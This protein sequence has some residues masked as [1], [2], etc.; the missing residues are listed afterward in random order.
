MRKEIFDQLEDRVRQEKRTVWSFD[1][2]LQLVKKDPLKVLRNIFQLFHDMVVEYVGEG[3][4]EYP[5]DPESIGFVKYDCSKI[6]IEGT[7]EPFFPDRLF[8]NRFVR[9][10]KS[11]RQGSR[12]N[13][14]YAY[15]GPPGCGKSRFLN[16]LMG[17]FERYVNSEA[18][19]SYELFWEIDESRY[20]KEVSGESKSQPRKLEVPC[21]NHDYPIL[22]IP[23][24]F[25]K[26]FL[27]QLLGDNGED[28][29]EKIFEEKEYQWISK[30]EVCT[31]CNSIF[32]ELFEKCGS[33]NKVLE[34]VKVRPY[35]F[36]RRIGEGIS[37]FN[38]GDRPPE[39]SYFADKQLQTQLDRLFGFNKVQYLFSPL[40]RTNNGIYVL[41]DVKDH[42]KM[43]L[44]ELH[45][46]ISE[47]VHKVGGVI[48]ENINSLFFALMNPEDKAVL[49]EQKGAQSIHG[50]I[51][52]N[53]ITYVLEVQ[54]EMKIYKSVFGEHIALRFLPHVLENFCRIIIAS[55]MN[56]ECPPLK[57]WIKDLTKYKRY[58]DKEGRLLRMEL[59]SGVIPSWLS[60][61]DRK[62]FS[63]SARRKLITEAERE[64]LD[65]ATG[66]RRGFT[67]RDSIQLFAEFFTRYGSRAN[68]INMAN[69][70][71][72]FKHGIGKEQRDKYIPQEF[73]ASLE[74]WYDY[75]VLNEVK[76]A[77]YFYNKNQ[78][79][80]DILH[81][82]WAVNYDLGAKTRCSYT[83]KE[84][85]VTIDF[86]KLIGGYICGRQLSDEEAKTLALNYQK[87]YVQFLSQDPS[88]D[89]TQTEFYQDLLHAYTAN[90]KEKALQP[91]LKNETFREAIKSFGTQE[92][93]PF[94]ERLKEHVRHMIKTLVERFGYTEEGA[95]EVC[96]Y[97]LDKRLTEKF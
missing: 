55:R 84:I 11:L 66:E 19:R 33:L 52:Y 71:E 57:E 56:A 2:Y 38:P 64:G 61:E 21:P 43:R 95:R 12:Q 97:V 23:K 36:N 40:S 83:N 30:N 92:F 60:D 54:T 47:G 48:E 96:L 31:I 53:T 70:S 28:I 1:E 14:L 49:D 25:R 15:L 88:Q 7:D 5:G 69:V 85:E 90:L 22:L 63:A 3:E 32:W 58:C 80:Q 4:D 18:G 51:Q 35:K 68:L 87:K 72:Y 13:H 16:N 82:L 9:Q 26:E 34:F 62:N 42:N 6:F 46:V 27:E 50:R 44:L 81:Y 65:P 73:L 24:S 93:E 89:I 67:G 8:A 37:I 39:R 91:F 77:L 29:C 75:S 20:W 94:D 10:T 79:V 86:L 45:N 59:Y 74:N 76:E 41:M 17:A 78:I